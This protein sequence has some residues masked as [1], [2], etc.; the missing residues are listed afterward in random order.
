VSRSALADHVPQTD[1]YLS[2]T[3]AVL[4]DDLLILTTAGIRN[5]TAARIP[6]AAWTR[7]KY[8]NERTETPQHSKRAVS[9]T[10]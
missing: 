6:H 1:L 9:A 3:H 4:I 7:Q 8:L 10:S 5:F 2:P